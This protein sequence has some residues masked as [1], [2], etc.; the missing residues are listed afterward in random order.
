MISWQAVSKHYL[1]GNGQKHQALDAVDLTIHPHEFIAMVGRSGSGKSTAMYL[2]GLLDRPS[3][4][5][6]YFNKKLV[7]AMSAEE[8]ASLRNQA[9]GFVFQ[10]YVLLP[11]L[12]VAENIALP[13][14]YNPLIK[15][16]EY[17]ARI[18]RALT[19]VSMLDY[20]QQRPNQLSGGQQQRVAIA[21]ALICEPKLLLADEP[22]GSL[23]ASNGQQIIKLFQEINSQLGTT[24]VMVTHDQLWAKYCTRTLQ[25]KSGKVQDEK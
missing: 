14:A 17:P 25:V 1:W 18:E 19:A 20:Q 21:R 24:I 6:Y 16:I 9:I 4:G 2:L 15:Q 11:H 13:L 22:T 8:A 12:T 5:E 23:D 3:S 10:Q 7:S